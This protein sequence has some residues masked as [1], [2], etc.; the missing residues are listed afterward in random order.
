MFSAACAAQLAAH[1]AFIDS[2]E[3]VSLNVKCDD[4][5]HVADVEPSKNPTSS[6]VKRV[7]YILKSSIS[8]FSRHEFVPPQQFHECIPSTML[9]AACRVGIVMSYCSTMTKLAP[10]ASYDVRVPLPYAIAT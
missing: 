2:V 7:L 4:S 10:L 3:E 9:C 5:A 1:S 6:S 8:Q